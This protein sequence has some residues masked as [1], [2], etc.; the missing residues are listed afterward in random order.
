M[1]AKADKAL[2]ALKE[3]LSGRDLL[4]A[5]RDYFLSR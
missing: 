5:R 1:Q 2:A 3:A 4:R